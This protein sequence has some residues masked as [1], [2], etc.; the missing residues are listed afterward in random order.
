MDMQI[1]SIQMDGTGYGVESIGRFRWRNIANIGQLGENS[2]QEMVAKLDYEQEKA[3]VADGTAWVSV[4]T[5]PGTP[6]YLRSVADN[7]KADN[8]LSLPRF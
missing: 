7:T 5:V 6:K 2:K 4:V 1:Y 8:L 3:W